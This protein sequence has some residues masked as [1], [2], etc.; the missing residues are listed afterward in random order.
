MFTWSSG[1]V[2]ARNAGDWV[3]LGGVPGVGPADVNAKGKAVVGLRRR[4]NSLLLHIELKY[5]GCFSTLS[6]FGRG[7]EQSSLPGPMVP[8]LL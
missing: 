6:T 4:A 2:L 5:Y 1:L 3:R 7:C 8:P